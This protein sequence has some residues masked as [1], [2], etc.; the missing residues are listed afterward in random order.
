MNEQQ[1][2]KKKKIIDY[3]VF[4]DDKYIKQLMNN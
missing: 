1:I 2:K 3:L 4:S